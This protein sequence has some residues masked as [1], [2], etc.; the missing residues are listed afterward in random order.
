VVSV[1]ERDDDDNYYD[2]DAPDEHDKRGHS[3]NRKEDD[4]DSTKR[5]NADDK[6]FNEDGLQS[7]PSDT[8]ESREFGKGYSDI[9]GVLDSNEDNGSF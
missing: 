6:D 3:H 4:N 2:D 8:K 7:F 5:D 9:E 1:I